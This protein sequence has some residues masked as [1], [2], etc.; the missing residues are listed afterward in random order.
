MT[1][2]ATGTPIEASAT[3]LPCWYDPFRDC[4]EK[5]DSITHDLMLFAVALFGIGTGLLFIYFV[6]LP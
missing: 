3:L 4:S 5:V 1:G 6:I 2:T